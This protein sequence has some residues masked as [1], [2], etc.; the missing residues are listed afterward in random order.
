MSIRSISIEYD[1]Y[2]VLMTDE[3]RRSIKDTQYSMGKEYGYE[4]ALGWRKTILTFL[5]Q[6][7]QPRQYFGRLGEIDPTHFS[8]A[9]AHRQVPGTKTT[10]FFLVEGDCIYMVTS[11]FSRRNWPRVLADMAREIQSQIAMLKRK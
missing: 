10:V 3:F 2:R 4:Y 8:D 7:E 6:F 9:Y 1:L 5:K 11:G